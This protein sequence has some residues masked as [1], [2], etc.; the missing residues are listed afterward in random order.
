M[1]GCRS[2]LETI[3]LEES[4]TIGTLKVKMDTPLK[5]LL[6]SLPQGDLWQ[7]AKILECLDYILKSKLLMVPEE[8]RDLVPSLFVFE[9]P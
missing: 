4:V 3:L 6:R 7:D 1:I 8:Y 5:D 9:K 2:F